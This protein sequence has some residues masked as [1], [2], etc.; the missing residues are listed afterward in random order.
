MHNIKKY[1]S[2]SPTFNLTLT[3]LMQLNS[4]INDFKWKISLNAKKQEILR[5]Q[6]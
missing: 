5:E 3:H 2:N 6:K 4:N 1:F